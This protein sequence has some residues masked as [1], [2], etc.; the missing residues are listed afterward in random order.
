[1]PYKDKEKKA[2]WERKNRG[3]G[4]THAIW[5]GYL[6]FD[7]APE[8]WEQRIRESGY[9]CVWAVHDKDVRATGE[10]KETHV[11]I[12]VRFSHA[13]DASTAKS[14]LTEFGV[15]EASV[16]FRDSWRAVCRYMVHMDD[17]DKYQ[18][19]P[20]IVCECGGADWHTEIYRTS[21]KYA[22]VAAMQD[23][24]DD[25]ANAKANGCPPQFNDLMRYA[26][27]NQQ[28]WFMALCDSSAIVMREYCKANRHDWRDDRWEVYKNGSTV[29]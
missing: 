7:S 8:D 10:V 11:H 1:M 9:E 22:V 28:E 17:P 15:K 16:Q 29:K 19:D 26:R 13:V 23:W 25:Q 6:Y 20:S 12:A 2:Q 21:D 3:K 24:C 18:Y 14:V 5:W 4:T 27:A